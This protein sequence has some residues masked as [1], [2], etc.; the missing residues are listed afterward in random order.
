MTGSLRS[1][2]PGTQR[3]AVVHRCH[4]GSEPWPQVLVS[5]EKAQD[6]PSQAPPLA[7]WLALLALEV[8]VMTSACGTT[9]TERLNLLPLQTVAKVDLSRYAGTWYEIA[10][11]PHRFQEGCTGTIATYTLR[12]DGEIG[13]VNRCRKGSLDGEERSVEGRARAVDAS[14]NAKL[15]VTFF[16]PFWGDYWVIDLGASYEY[17][18][19]GHPSRDYLWILSRTLTME[20]T[21]YQRILDRLRAKGYRLDRLRKT[22]QPAVA[23]VSTAAGS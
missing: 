17:T 23:P 2:A 14:T 18:V 9:T 1:L 22:L 15:E 13:V 5:Q 19:V 7:A 3:A 20:D 11:F 4:S 8:F 10:S 12:D 16:W 6:R 21:A